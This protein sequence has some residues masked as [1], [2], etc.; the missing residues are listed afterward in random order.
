MKKRLFTQILAL[1]LIGSFLTGCG[2]TSATKTDTAANGTSPSETFAPTYAP[3]YAPVNSSQ[4][5]TKYPY[6]SDTAACEEGL[7]YDT[8]DC[9]I[10]YYEKENGESYAVIDENGFLSVKKHP[11]STFSADVDTASYSNLRRMIYDGYSLER[12]DPNAVRIEEMLNYFSYDYETPDEGEP[13]SVNSQIAPCPWNEDN[14]LL[15]LGLQTEEIDFKNAPASNLVFLIDVSGSMYSEDKLPLLQKSFE[16]LCTNLTSKDRVSIVT[17]AGSDSIVLQGAKGNDTDTIVNAL[18]S[19]SAG[20]S[21]NGSAGIKTAYELAEEYYI[22]EGNNRVILATDGDLNV[23][24]TSNDGLEKLITKKRNSGIFLSV[25]GFGTGNI[26]DD[27]MEILADKGNG[28]YSYIDSLKEAKKVLVEE[29]GATLVTVAKDVKFQL[30]FNEDVVASYRQ[31]GYEN[32][33]LADEDFDDDTKDAGEVGAGSSVT[34]LYE[35][36][37]TDKNSD[38]KKN[39]SWVDLH[40]RYKEPDSDTSTESIYNIGKKSLIGKATGDI[41]FA[42]AVT[43]FGMLIRESEYAGTSSPSQI[44]S[45]LKDADIRGDEYKE[46][47]KVLVDLLLED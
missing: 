5:T 31:I 42:A 12:I 10:P 29:M 9:F 36:T 32:R 39:A 15:M 17:Y 14:Y 20:G 16:M 2:M 24:I 23:G 25:L 8:N 46:E 35:L 27:K 30:E 19:L 41:A 11:L 38:A 28:N 18:E 40:I 45:L 21:T 43:E 37:L 33:A 26:K 34:V 44:N 22:E 47:F 4:S 7:F 3:T 13:F 6:V 1:S